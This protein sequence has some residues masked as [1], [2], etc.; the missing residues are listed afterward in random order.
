MA[1]CPDGLW[2]RV[3]CKYNKNPV[4]VARW[5][6]EVE[7]N[8]QAAVEKARPAVEVEGGRPPD[9]VTLGFSPQI[10]VS[11]VAARLNHGLD[12]A[13]AVIT[14][15]EVH[16]GTLQQAMLSNRTLRALREAGLV[17]AVLEARMA[18]A[19]GVPPVKVLEELRS[20]FR[21]ANAMGLSGIVDVSGGTQL[22]PIA[23][24]QES[25]RTLSYTY[26]EG[27]RVAIYTFRV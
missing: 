18:P 14:S 19:P 4:D 6:A 12:P 8:P 22:V 9:A 10:L 11:A 16:R 7:S 26:P 3:F 21:R 17:S 15:P 27:E 20:A 5:V 24:L 1:R 2:A 23:A 13:V 25:I